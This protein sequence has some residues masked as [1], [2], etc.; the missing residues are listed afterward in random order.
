VGLLFWR[1][2]VDVN[3]P[4]TVLRRRFEQL[5]LLRSLYARRGPRDRLSVM[6]VDDAIRLAEG[7]LS[8]G[9]PVAPKPVGVSDSATWSDSAI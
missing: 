9:G 1:D 4:T 6:T 5:C 2:D 8:A 7:V 3:T